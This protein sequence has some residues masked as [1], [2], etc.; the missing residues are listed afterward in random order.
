VS[1]PTLRARADERF[2]EA[3]ERTGGRDPRDFLRQRLLVLREQDRD[4]YRRAVDHFENHLIT[5]VADP[6]SDPLA[7]WLEYSRVLAASFEP[8]RTVQIDAT[9]RAE[10][11]APPVP[12]D[13]LVLHLP[14]DSR[15]PALVVGLPAQL[16]AAQRAAYDLLV[17][18][19][20]R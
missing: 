5:A 9:G 15:E 6:G 17:A 10:P 2:R 11:Y 19:K 12:L 1:D 20:V 13:C 8:G 4:A 18:R 7:E 14:T 16:S 3:L